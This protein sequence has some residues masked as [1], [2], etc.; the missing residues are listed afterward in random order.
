MESENIIRVNCSQC[1]G[2]NSEMIIKTP[3]YELNT[4]EQYEVSRCLSCRNIYTSVRP[5]IA[6][7]FTKHYPD[8]YICYGGKEKSSIINIDHIRMY[9]QAL[10]RAKILTKYL[11]KKSEVRMLEIGC[12]TGE[13]LKVGSQKFGWKVTGIEPNKKLSDKLSKEG[14]QII[15]SV[16]ENA[17]ISI[18][19]YDAV[20]LFNVFE[21]LWDCAYSLRR[22]NNFLKPDGL[23]VIE[24]PDFDA[25]ARKVFGKYWFLYHL[26][27]H[28]SHFN[29]ESLNSLMKEIGFEPVAIL[30]QFRPTVN[31]LSLKYW[32]REKIKSRI[33][34]K[35]ITQS[36]P[37]IMGIGI[38]LE[39]FFSIYGNSNHIIAIYRKKKTVE[40]YSSLLKMVPEIA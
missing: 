6:T 27:R 19:Y 3:D 22:I 24:I 40:V 14:F 13:F 38:L 11:P 31:A 34:K 16:M 23:V 28:L 20:C 25:A 4:K 33:M 36:N 2:W 29:R 8:D 10:Q 9:S 32:A 17:E 30:K 15:N 5:D 12:A 1:G 37:L 39:L 18:D 35:F 21:H 7:L 26:P